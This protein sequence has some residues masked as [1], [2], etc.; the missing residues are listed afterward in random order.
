ME[1]TGFVDKVNKNKLMNKFSFGLKNTKDGETR[2][3]ASI[4]T[5]KSPYELKVVSPRLMRLLGSNEFTVTADHLPGKQLTVKSSYQQFKFFF[6]HGSIPDG[7]NLFAEISKA[8]VSFLKY[9]LNLEFK[10]DASAINMGLLSLF[11]VNEASMFYPVFCSYASGCFKQRKAMFGIFI[12]LVNKNALI[13]KFDI[14]GNI[15]KDG[16]KAGELVF[17]TN[18]TPYKFMVKAPHVLPKMIGQPSMEVSATHNLG[19]SLE[20]TTNF[21]KL[22]SF[23]VKKTGGNMREVK[24]N[25]KLLFKGEVTKGDRSFKQQVELGNGQKM[26]ITVSWEKDV[27]DVSSVRN[28][29]IKFNIAGNNVNVDFKANWDV[30]NPSAA[31]LEVEAKGNGPNLGKFEFSRN[32]DWTY[33]HNTFKTNIVGKSS[34]EKGWFAEKGINPVDTKINV[35]WTYNHNT[36]K[37]NIVKV[38]AGK[39]YGVSVKNNMLQMNM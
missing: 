33:N 22:K 19:Q 5:V 2:L 8:G 38:V 10:K 25:G 14:H 11:D 28:N 15:L 30:S 31:K 20:I 12:D 32:I 13:N 9:N 26:A 7:K 18:N 36:F 29:G 27:L 3:E 4:D 6:K 17:S 34:S 37:T 35:D 24:L 39:R 23:S 16:E 1:L 21:N